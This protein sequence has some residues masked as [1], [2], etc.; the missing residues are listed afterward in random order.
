MLKRTLFFSNPFHLNVKDEQLVIT[1]KDTGEIR[2]CPI[3]DLGFVILDHPQITLSQWAVQLL[4]ENNVAVVFCDQ[5]HHPSS[6]LFHL[7]TNCVQTEIF[8]NQIEAT[9]PLKKN[10]WKQTVESKIYNQAQLLKKLGKEYKLMEMY[11]ANVKSDDSTNQEAVA[12]RFYWQRLFDS[13]NFKR[14]RFGNPPNPSLN[15]GYA[16]LRAA[17]AR[18]LTGSGLL[19]TLGIHHSN[20]YNAYCLADDIME[21][22]RPFVDE[23]VCEQMKNN[24]D[25]H[26]INKERKAELLG[27][28]SCDVVFEKVKR[29]LMV[30]LSI[31]T[32]SLAKCFAGEQ[33]I[34]SYPE[35]E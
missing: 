4:A 10:L 13:E 1:N 35:M 17:V 27:V 22:F 9:E 21:P 24:T 23:I 2:Q 7:D 18:A 5:K 3:E 26:V 19:P 34:I 31:T 33:R 12:S 29:P 16:I 30:G 32:A 14:E 20:K 25:Y 15:F 28:L 8:R 6:M 11:A